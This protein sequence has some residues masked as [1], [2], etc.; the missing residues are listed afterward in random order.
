MLRR[1]P[2]V[3]ARAVKARRRVDDLE[4]D[5]AEGEAPVGVGE[6][7]ARQQVRLAEH[8]KAVADAEHEPAVAANSITDSIAGEKRA[9]APARR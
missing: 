2:G 8:L 7:R 1:S 4:R 3:A 9:I 6:Q 5:L